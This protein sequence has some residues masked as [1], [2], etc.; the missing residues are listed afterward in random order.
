MNII[1]TR[2]P[3]PGGNLLWYKRVRGGGGV[4]L[5]WGC[6]VKIRHYLLTYLAVQIAPLRRGEIDLAFFGSAPT[7]LVAQTALI[8]FSVRDHK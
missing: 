6:F 2:V 7:P 5:E 4:Y 8:K 1:N 3:Q